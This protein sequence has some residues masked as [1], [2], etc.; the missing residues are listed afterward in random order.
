MLTLYSMIDSGNCYKV[1]LMLAKLGTAFRHLETQAFDGSTRRPDF[2]LKNPNGKV[3]LL[4]L[5]DGR[6]LAE[7]NAIL[8]YLAEGT[9]FVPDDR[10]ERAL[11]HQW[12]FFEQYSHEP[13][14]AVRRSLMKHAQRAE[15][16][17][18]DKMA[19][20]LEGGNRALKVME[21]VLGERAFVAGNTISAADIALYA[22]T[23]DAAAGGFD[24]TGFPNVSRWLGRVAA[25]AG[26]V[27]LQWVPAAA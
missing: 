3:P 27:P 11:V 1:R 22:Y 6:T 15:H 13:F 17:T 26:H 19:R 18:P 24:L 25:D 14:I 8:L 7:S 21:T 9:R 12:M 5:E 4:E 16:A 20:L 10:Y 2:L 23:H